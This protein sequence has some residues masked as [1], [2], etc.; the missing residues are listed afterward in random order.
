MKKNKMNYGYLLS[1]YDEWQGK[2]GINL[3]ASSHIHMLVTGSSGSGKSTSVLWLLTNYLKTVSSKV[4]ICDFKG[5]SEWSFLREYPYYYSKIDCIHGIREYYQLYKNTKDTDNTFCLLVL[6]EYPALIGYLNVQDKLNK[7]KVALEI[8]GI[9]AE[10]LAMGRSLHCGI[11]VLA[12]RPDA[13][14]FANGS[15]D[16]FMVQIALGN[17]SKEH[18]QML[19]SGCELPS[20]RIYKAG[21][22]ILYA[23]GKGIQEVK[24]PF[25]NNIERWQDNIK[26]KL[27]DNLLG[28]AEGIDE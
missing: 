18:R 7:T 13:S 9:V 23:D 5:G 28:D 20:D 2:V 3:S 15:R 27:M 12:Q 17:I 1:E 22:G 25:L 10:I 11:W 21:E 24:Y 19:F 14:L 8:Q 26:R 16:N 6:D 4:F